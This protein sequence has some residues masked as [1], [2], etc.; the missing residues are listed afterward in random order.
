M[1]TSFSSFYIQSPTI[2]GYNDYDG[3]ATNNIAIISPLSINGN[4]QTGFNVIYGLGA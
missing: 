4:I 2:V 3:S 1:N